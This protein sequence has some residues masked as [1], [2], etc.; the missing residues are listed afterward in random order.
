M[1][2]G[3]VVPSHKIDAVGAGVVSL[4]PGDKVFGFTRF[5]AYATH[6]TVPEGYARKMPSEWNFAEGASFV[7]QGM[8]LEKAHPCSV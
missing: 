1:L 6:V 4:E 2:H 7:V 3:C 8:M 5:G